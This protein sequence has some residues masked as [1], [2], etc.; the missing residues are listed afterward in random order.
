MCGHEVFINHQCFYF[1]IRVNCRSEA[2]KSVVM[3]YLS[4]I[5]VLISIFATPVVAEP[6]KIVVTIFPLAEMVKE[7]GGAEVEV[8]LLLKSG[9]GPHTFE[10]TPGDVRKIS[11]ADIVVKAG[12]DLEHWLEPLIA[13]ASEKKRMILSLSDAVKKPIRMSN[14]NQHY[15][16]DVREKSGAINPHYWLDPLIMVE[17]VK[18]ISETLSDIRPEKQKYF[19]GR[20]EKVANSLKLLDKLL[21]QKL[22]L[23]GLAKKV[24]AF[25]G[26][27]DYFAA[28]YGIA[29]AG[30]IEK[31]PGKEPSAKHF[32]RLIKTIKRLEIK[33]VLAEPQM[34]PKLSRSLA[35]EA[36]AKVVIVDPIGGGEGRATYFEL[37]LWNTYQFIKALRNKGSL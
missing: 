13:S 16:S 8:H 1:H 23:P 18:L 28:R 25:H 31:A 4:V 22:G 19:K 29:I 26:S 12:F 10:P 9:S 20:T 21:R 30:V 24:V 15:H 5:S 32:A 27:W 11:N 35:E 2:V 34:S 14:H 33:S 17:V 7:V 37:M 3:R 36:G 6:I